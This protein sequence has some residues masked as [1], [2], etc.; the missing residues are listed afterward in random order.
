MRRTSALSA[1]RRALARSWT[2]DVTSVSAGPPVGGLYLK[3]PSSGGLCD[4]VMTMPSARGPPS[5]RLWGGIACEAAGCGG[6]GG[7]EAG[8]GGV[9]PP[10]RVHA[11][12]DAVRG[13][14]LHRRDGGGLRQRVRVAR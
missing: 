8:G 13:E 3:P 6:G 11:H 9:G 7:G 5:W 10:R 1:R 14:H 2:R 4:G 12:V